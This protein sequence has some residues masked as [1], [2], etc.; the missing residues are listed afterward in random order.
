[1]PRTIPG[2]V[3]AAFEILLEEIEGVVSAYIRENASAC[4]ARDFQTARKMIERAELVTTFRQ[5]VDGVRREWAKLEKLPYEPKATPTTGVSPTGR[6]PRGVRTPE[7]AFY[8]PILES[9]IELD[10]SAAV[11]DVLERVGTKMKGILKDVDYQTV[12]SDPDEPR[13]RNT[14][15]WARNSLVQDGR[16]KSGSRYGTWE[17]TQAG[18]DWV[19][20]KPLET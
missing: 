17:I 11:G 20:T 2:N 4:Q 5:K 3:D 10:G 15:K 14:A 7:D 19:A 16:L 9:L 6:L 13:W 1:M 8:L 12:P 18:R